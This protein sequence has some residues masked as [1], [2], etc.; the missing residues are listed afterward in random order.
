M[1]IYKNV[2]KLLFIALLFC[3][4]SDK[5]PEISSPLAQ[6][7]FELKSQNQ[8]YILHISKQDESYFFAMFDYFGAPVV[9][10]EFT[11]SK[12]KNAKFMPANNKFDKLFYEILK[13]ALN[14][15]T[16]FKIENFE[17][18]EINN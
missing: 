8:A 4:C 5:Y 15:K 17:I 14:G 1:R 10:K 18:K 3:A 11:K 13:K 16:A 9:S 7:S 6:K 2:I 12:F